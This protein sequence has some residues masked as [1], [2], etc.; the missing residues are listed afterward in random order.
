M[1]TSSVGDKSIMN[2]PLLTELSAYKNIS[3]EGVK[4]LTN[5]ISLNILDNKILVSVVLET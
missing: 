4:H 1:S 5:L 3:D 2:L